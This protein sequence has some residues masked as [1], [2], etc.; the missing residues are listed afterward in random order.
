MKEILLKNTKFNT[1]KEYQDQIVDILLNNNVEFELIEKVFD[2]LNSTTLPEEQLK[3]NLRKVL[4][5][6]NLLN[7]GIIK[8][9]NDGG[10]VDSAHI[11][12]EFLKGGHIVVDDDGKMAETLKVLNELEARSRSNHSHYRSTRDSNI[13]GASISAEPVFSEI[14]FGV[15]NY[16]DSAYGRKVSWI[17][18]EGAGIGTAKDFV[19]H[20]AHFVE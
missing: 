20:A 14:L 9:D 7:S 4:V 10:G 19:A 1:V 11:F 17:Q 13:G 16:L 12:N 5:I 8:A 18:S 3:V 6:F 2:C 15:G